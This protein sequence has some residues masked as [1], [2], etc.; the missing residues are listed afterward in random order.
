MDKFFKELLQTNNLEYNTLM[1]QI[2]FYEPSKRFLDLSD[3]Q[4][5]VIPSSL[6]NLKDLR[7]LCLSG[8]LIEHLPEEIGELTNL[9]ILRK[10][11]IAHSFGRA[12]WNKH[13]YR[14]IARFLL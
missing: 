4:L 5:E 6:G 11:L 1:D 8:N 9:T 13:Y 2:H 3:L 14:K 12:A 10:I 7:E